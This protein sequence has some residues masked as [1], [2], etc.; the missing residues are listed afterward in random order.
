VDFSNIQ[1]NDKVLIHAG[2]G[3]VGSLGIQIAKH[4][5]AYVA[6]TASKEN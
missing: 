1:K 2:A 6:T 5:G 4:F 3:G